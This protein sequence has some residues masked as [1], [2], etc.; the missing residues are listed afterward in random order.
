[1]AARWGTAALRYS[2]LAL[3][4]ARCW[5]SVY[6]LQKEGR[7]FPHPRELL[8]AMGLGNLTQLSAAQHM[9]VMRSRG[10]T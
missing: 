10:V 2:R 9:Q 1:M 3:E 6:E 7:A 5:V 8:D 4:A